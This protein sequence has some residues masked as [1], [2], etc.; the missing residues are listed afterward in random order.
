MLDEPIIRQV[1]KSYRPIILVRPKDQ[2]L[3]RAASGD[4]SDP[5]LLEIRTQFAKENVAR[6]KLACLTGY[7]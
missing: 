4:G 6:K 7:F 2:D 5:Y 1:S 3:R